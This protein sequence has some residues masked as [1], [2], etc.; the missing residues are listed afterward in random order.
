MTSSLFSTLNQMDLQL[1]EHLVDGTTI[2]AAL[3]PQQP[4]PSLTALAGGGLTG[5]PILGLGINN[6]AT[7]ASGGDSA[8]LPQALQGSLIIVINNGAQSAYVW[9][10]SGDT[11]VPA[12]GS[13][14]SYATVAA[15][16]IVTFFCYAGGYWKASV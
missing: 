13:T 9:P 3:A 8:A 11:L 1:G 4:N 12:A 15:N 14:E 7:V 10:Q 5:A 2:R 16:A 6:L